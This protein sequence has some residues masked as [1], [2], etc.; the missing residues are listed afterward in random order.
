MKKALIAAVLL[1]AIISFAACSGGEQGAESTTAEEK[2]YLIPT[3]AAR[4]KKTKAPFTWEIETTA[5]GGSEAQAENSEV[6]ATFANITVK[7][8]TTH[9]NSSPSSN[10]GQTTARGTSK[11]ASST[12]KSDN[13]QTETKSFAYEELKITLSD[14]F[15]KGTYKDCDAYYYSDDVEIYIKK[16][17]FSSSRALRDMNLEEYGNKLIEEN[18]MG[19]VQLG[20]VNKLTFFE[21]IGRERYETQKYYHAVF[22]YKSS[23]AFWTVD[24]RTDA[25]KAQQK[26]DLF[27]RWAESV[28]FG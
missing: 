5:P 17:E 11:K 21:F 2:T 1:A 25:E 18:D 22:L 24:F 27:I 16:D 15:K 8:F 7:P 28:K 4:V 14:D 26:V 6:P 20:T 10:P 13:K 23:T 3:T 9:K 19:S 12:A